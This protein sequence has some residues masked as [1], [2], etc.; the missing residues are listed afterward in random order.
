MNIKTDI[1]Y[2]LDFVSY[3]PNTGVDMSFIADVMGK[4]RDYI[5]RLVKILEEKEKI[6]VDYKSNGNMILRLKK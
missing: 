1:A 6:E 5:E 3:F 2:V 4:K